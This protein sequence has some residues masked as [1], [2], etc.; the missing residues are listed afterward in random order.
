VTE[1]L[2]ALSEP[3]RVELGQEGS[4][5]F[6]QTLDESV[7]LRSSTFRVLLAAKVQALSREPARAEAPADG[8]NASKGSAAPAEEDSSTP[9]SEDGSEVP[10]DE[11]LEPPD[12]S[13]DPLG[14]PGVSEEEVATDA[15][16]T[17]EHIAT[18]ESIRDGRTCFDGVEPGAF[19][20]VEEPKGGRRVSASYSAGRERPWC[21]SYLDEPLSVA[22]GTGFSV[23]FWLEL[24]DASLE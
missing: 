5:S 13:C 17:F 20:Y 21:I 9:S 10:P 23:S 1:Q 12:G 16:S 15:G 24:A 4:A 11:E 8:E 19:V 7:V 2:S 14:S 3:Q 22:I 6:I 18:A